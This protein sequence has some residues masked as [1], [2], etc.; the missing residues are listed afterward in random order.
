M[1]T[2]KEKTVLREAGEKIGGAAI[3]TGVEKEAASL[4][5]VAG[6]TV[7]A[8]AVEDIEVVMIAEAAAGKDI[9]VV[10]TAEE[11]AEKETEAAATAE[12]AGMIVEIAGTGLAKSRPQPT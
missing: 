5:A 1:T 7:K 12:A 8:G 2:K 11:V 10:A 3:E 4:S 6:V 9:A